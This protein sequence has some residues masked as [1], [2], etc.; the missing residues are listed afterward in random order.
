VFVG[1]GLGFSGEGNRRSPEG[2][3]EESEV[4]VVEAKAWCERGNQQYNLGRFSEAISSYNH[5]ISLQP[6]YYDALHNRDL[7]QRK[8][9]Q[10]E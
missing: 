10:I 5:A 4:N 6:D 7:A 2:A 1:D 3:E 9:E 8:L